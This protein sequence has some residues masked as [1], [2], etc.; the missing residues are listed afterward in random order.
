MGDEKRYT[1]EESHRHLAAS[2]FNETWD[3]L[4]QEDR[5]VEQDARMVNTAYASRYHWGEVGKP[6]HWAVGEWQIA[7]VHATLDHPD[8]SLRHA[9]R[10]LEILEENGITGFHLASA[11]EGLARAYS[12]AG[13]VEEARRYVRL[14][15][16][17]GDKL[18]D[19][20]DKEVLMD[21]LSDLP[22][23]EA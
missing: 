12:V 4:E 20:E 5:T 7:R 16:Q 21:Q 23:F 15:Q 17:E 9:R 10:A 1:L 11:Y 18:T 3:L 19:P 14:A 6:K 13:D 22:E 8:S 2:L